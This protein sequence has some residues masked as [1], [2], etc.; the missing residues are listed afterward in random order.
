[1]SYIVKKLVNFFFAKILISI[2]LLTVSLGTQCFSQSKKTNFQSLQNGLSNQHVRCIL[3]DSKGFMWFGTNEGLNKFDGS[4]FR[5]YENNVNDSNSLINNSINVL[6][7]DK[8]HNLW[9]GTSNGLCIYNAEKDNF[10]VFKDF[11]RKQ[12]MYITTLLEDN[13]HIWIGT[14]GSGIFMYDVK[15]DAFYHYLND[16]KIESSVSSNFVNIM[17]SDKKNRIWIGSHSGLDLYDKKSNTFIPIKNNG[18]NIGYTRSL[19]TDNEGNLWLGTFGRGLYKITGHEN[20]WQFEHFDASEKPG[21]LSTNDILTLLFDKDGNLWVGTENGGLNFLPAHAKDFII[22]KNEDG[23]P[24]SIGSNSIWSLYQDVS[25]IVWI[26]TFNHGLNFIDEKIEKFEVYQRNH[27]E[28]KTLVN[29]NVVNFAEDAQGNIWIATD[30]GGV[31]SFDIR[32]HTFTNKID[33][34]YISSK[35]AMAVLC[36]SKQRIW[37]GTWGGGIDLFD[38]SGKKIRNYKIYP[39]KLPSNILYLMED[40]TGNIWACSVGNGLLIYDPV[41]DEFTKVIDETDRTHL[42]DRSYPNVMFQDSENTIWVGLSFSLVSIKYV[43]GKRVFAEYIHSLNPGSI[44]SSII[45]AI[46]ED[47]HNNIW[48]GTDNGLNLLNKKT[49]TFTIFRKESGLPNNSINGILEDNNKCLWIGTYN[50]IS[51]FDTEHKTFKNYSKEDGL[52]SNSFNVRSCLKT[53]KGEFFFG[54]NSGFVTFSSDRIETNTY[55]PPVYFT[56]LKIFNTPA[57]IGGKGSPLSKSITDTRKIV[58]NYKQT[59]FT[60]EFVAL[61]FTHASKNQYKYKLEG[62]DTGWVNAGTERYAT[63]TNINPGRYTFKV[64]GS[65]NH[66]IWNPKP[67]ALEIVILPPFWKTIWAYLIYSIIISVILWGFIKLLLIKSKQA[68]K[69]RLEQIHYKKSEELNRMK[70]QFFAN[71][72]HEFRTP[73][74]LILPPLKQIIENEPL[75][76]ET[77]KRMEMVFRNAS[78]L[79]GLVN[80]LLDFTKSEE[81]RLKMKVEK[82]DLVTFIH[83]IHGA[84]I[85]EAHRRSITYQF[86]VETESIE[87]WFDKNKI[88]KVVSNLLSNAFK[89]TGDNGKIILNVRKEE[90]NSESFACISVIDNGSGISPSYINNIFDRFYQSPEEENKHIAGTGIGLALVKTLVELHHG[91]VSVTSRKWEETCFTVR[92]P[93][94]NTHFNKNE[95]WVDADEFMLTNNVSVTLDSDTKDK[96]AEGN[97]P[98]LLVVE[99]NAELCEYLVSILSPKYH[100][101]KAADGAEGL[102]IARESVPDLILSDVVMPR[103]SGTELCKAIKNEMSTSHIPVVLLTSK[104]TTPEVIDGIGSGADAYITKPF[105]ILH[106]EVTIEKTIETR[107]K[108]YQRFS[109]NVYIMPKEST[110]NDLDKKFIQKIL[111]YIDQNVLN[112]NITVENLAAHM[113]MSRTNVYRKIKALT[114]Q[115]ATEFIRLTRLK[116]AIKLLEAGENNVSEIAY[117]VG[118]TSPSYFAKC[119]RDQYGKSPSEFIDTK[120]RKS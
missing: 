107:R 13:N 96:K 86:D 74:S 50:G 30:G 73:L 29:N 70:I 77:K 15:N 67:I 35:A 27:F 43:N 32:T 9:I 109:Q 24:Q 79:F 120:S 18:S 59:S 88:E 3:K 2:V 112:D 69:L 44:S 103:L 114:G 90:D 61:N 45:T 48:V 104:A 99:D 40:N 4:N 72:S 28:S 22:Y 52:P 19:T 110:E 91:S 20:E 105:D 33:N 113:L 118:F 65:N 49:G 23:N 94:G 111:T 76:R 98:L 55:I 116:M 60:F 102:R 41:K 83:E 25:G 108:L 119:F 100:V 82:A 5:I 62:F 117:K 92:I 51:K 37:V 97:A 71:I 11:G 66:G 63:Y 31:S 26:G 54:S 21:S 46:F 1:M 85:E 10:K 106:L 56:G 8:N 38:I 14:A 115:T 64:M 87:A 42:Q 16:P 6:L 58:L 36:D 84:F 12:F 78:K 47:S 17:V 34:K 39:Y 80:E 93:L 101:L 53:R 68:E 81:G 75:Q 95:I 57:V 89:F 7:E